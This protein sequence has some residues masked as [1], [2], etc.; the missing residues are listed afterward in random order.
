VAF[1]PE[2]PPLTPRT[3]VS[4]ASVAGCAAAAAAAPIAVPPTAIG[5]ASVAGAAAS[6]ASAADA[7]AG[8]GFG[9]R[10]QK[11]KRE[12]R[13]LLTEGPFWYEL[14]ARGGGS[15]QRESFHN[16]NRRSGTEAGPATRA[17][18]GCACRSASCTAACDARHRADRVYSLAR[19][20]PFAYSART[21][22][23][24]RK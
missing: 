15:Y 6:S 10:C 17:A 19:R 18:S 20:R 14:S 23:A 11:V 2:L 1:E 9:E 5:A 8:F 3:T 7:G 24:P 13:S 12:R 4:A 21:A 22:F 16:L